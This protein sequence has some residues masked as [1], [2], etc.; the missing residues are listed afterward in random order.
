MNFD[1]LYIRKCFDLA[2]KSYKNGD[3]LFGAIITH[4]NKIIVEAINTVALGDITGH[5]EINA[6]KELISKFPNISPSECTI[7]SNMEP[8]AMCSFLIRDVGIGRVVF[9]SIS[10]YMGGYTR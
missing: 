4:N 7:Y 3:N 6:M 8:C 2:Y 1:E 9:S 10:R 5:A